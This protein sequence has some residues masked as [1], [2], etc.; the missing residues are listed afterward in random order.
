VRPLRRTR[1]WLRIGHAD[2]VT[3]A[4]ALATILVSSVAL[5]AWLRLV[6]PN[7]DD[8]R[9]EIPDDV[10]KSTLLAF[11]ALFSL[12]NALLEEI[13]WRGVL[14]ESLEAG[15]GRGLVVLVLQA[16]SFGAAHIVGFPRGALGVLMAFVYG[17]ALGI[18]RRRSRGLAAPIVTHVFAD[19]TIFAL[20]IRAL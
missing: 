17:L 9:N 12:G 13:V 18:I 8:L 4:L 1:T 5:V 15:Y 16:A 20:L 19:A 11:G 10:S 6:H 14:M 2:R 3:I 7:L